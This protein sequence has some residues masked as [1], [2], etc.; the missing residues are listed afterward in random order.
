[1]AVLE[2]KLG[3]RLHDKEVILNVTGGIRI[4]DPSADLGVITAIM[5]SVLDKPVNKNAVFIGEVG[6]LGEIKPV[7]NLA[8]RVISAARQGFMRCVLPSTNVLHEK[9]DLPKGMEVIAL[10]S[11][12][13]LMDICFT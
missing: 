12:R 7:D 11:V 3:F 1:M 4:Y 2:K 13:E 8:V 5:S 10:E 6:L 9:N